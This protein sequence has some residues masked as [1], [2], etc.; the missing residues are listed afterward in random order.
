[1]LYHP[2]YTLIQLALSL[3]FYNYKKIIITEYIIF[4]FNFIYVYGHLA[5]WVC[6]CSAWCLWMT[7]QRTL[8]PLKLELRMLM[9]HHL[10]ARIEAPAS[11][12][13]CMFLPSGPS[14]QPLEFC[15]ACFE[16]VFLYSPGRP[17]TFT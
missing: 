13:Q 10:G 7:S 1:M 12:R 17:G 2:D 16:A 5:C 15:F 9:S 3:F 4:S 14:L 11:A 8:D 6:M